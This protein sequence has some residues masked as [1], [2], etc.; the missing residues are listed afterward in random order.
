MPCDRYSCSLHQ[1]PG[2]E[3]SN[4]GSFIWAVFCWL[5]PLC[6]CRAKAFERHLLFLRVGN[7]LVF[8]FPNKHPCGGLTG[9]SFLW[10]NTRTL[11]SPFILEFSLL[12]F[13]ASFMKWKRSKPVFWVP[14]LWHVGLGAS[15]VFLRSPHD[16]GHLNILALPCSFEQVPFFCT[17]RHWNWQKSLQHGY[18]PYVFRNTSIKESRF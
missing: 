16:V 14:K 18:M 15:A 1:D 4:R 5:Q 17:Y 7:C 12:S 6:V 13:F 8:F 11:R 9:P 2:K 3:R 10:K